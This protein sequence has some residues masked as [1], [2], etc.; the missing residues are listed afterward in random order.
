MIK[1]F[2]GKHSKERVT[3]M[4]C[5]KITETEKQ[6]LLII[7]KSKNQRCFKGIK[8]LETKYDFNKKKCE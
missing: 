8:S 3:V 4:V 6:K 7:G 5:S 1:C 2:G